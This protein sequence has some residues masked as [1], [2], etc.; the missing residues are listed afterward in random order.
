LLIKVI[1]PKDSLSPRSPDV[2]LI[3]CNQDLETP[4][5]LPTLPFPLAAA[6]QSLQDVFLRL[7]SLSLFLIL[8]PSKKK[9]LPKIL[10]P[11]LKSGGQGLLGKL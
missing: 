4:S 10:L 2:V 3:T 9:S 5:L 1:F 6:N 7:C 8:P 11:S